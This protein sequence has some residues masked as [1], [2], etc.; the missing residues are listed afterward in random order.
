MLIAAKSFFCQE[1]NKIVFQQIQ[2][3][4]KKSQNST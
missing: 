1:E 3:S 2:K 4:K